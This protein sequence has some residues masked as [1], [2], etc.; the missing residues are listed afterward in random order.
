MSK[1][2]GCEDGLLIKKAVKVKN[3]KD[4]NILMAG[5]SKIQ[6]RRIE[7]NVKRNYLRGLNLRDSRIWF[8]VRSRMTI[9][10]KANISLLFKDIM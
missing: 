9:R 2:L 10:I 8:R 6:D 1:E 7:D 5:K 4:L 3:D